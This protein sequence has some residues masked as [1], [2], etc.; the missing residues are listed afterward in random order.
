MPACLPAN[1]VVDCCPYVS[2]CRPHACIRVQFFVYSVYSV[3][4][5]GRM[6]GAFTFY[7]HFAALFA[8]NK[9]HVKIRI[10]S[11]LQCANG[12]PP[13]F[14]SLDHGRASIHR[15]AIDAPLKDVSRARECRTDRWNGKWQ[16]NTYIR[17]RDTTAWI[18]VM[19]SRITV[20]TNYQLVTISDNHWKMPCCDS[21]G[22]WILIFS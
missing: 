20:I 6:N 15:N 16:I 11:T 4:L 5:Y 3:L 2:A 19:K 14:H 9:N 22:L 10:N 21:K 1:E 17:E 7:W 12:R 13:V 8:L 18:K